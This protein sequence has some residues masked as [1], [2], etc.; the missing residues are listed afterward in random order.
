MGV[1]EHALI[2]LRAGYGVTL[3]DARAHGESEGAAATYGWLGRNDTRVIVDA[4]IASEHPTHIFALG[5][6]MGAGIALQSAGADPR[7]EA[8]VAEAPSPAFA[9]RRMTTQ[10]CK[11]THFS[12]KRFSRPVRG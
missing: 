8:V 2:L 11:S 9:K 1:V 7:I 12:A 3:L 5:E 4:L 10:V 6:S